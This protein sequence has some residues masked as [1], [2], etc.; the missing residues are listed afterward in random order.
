MWQQK[1]EKA[2]LGSFFDVRNSKKQYAGTGRYNLLWIITGRIRM[3]RAR[4]LLRKKYRVTWPEIKK[5]KVAQG[6]SSE[7][8]AR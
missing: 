3:R 7:E 1:H 4:K 2:S 6:T 5:L 8:W